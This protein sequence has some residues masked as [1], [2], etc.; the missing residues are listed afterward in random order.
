MSK[1]VL[2]IFVWYRSMR[3]GGLHENIR[4]SITAAEK[5]FERVVVVCPVSWFSEQ[6]LKV[7][8]EVLEVDFGSVSPE[9]VLQKIGNVNFVH[10]HPGQSRILGMKFAKLVQ[11]PVV[12][13][14]H[15]AWFDSVDRYWS[16]LYRVIAVS[17][18]IEFEIRRKI[19]EIRHKLVVINNGVDLGCFFSKDS[20]E[21]KK[22]GF[23]CASRF[24]IDK[25]KLL[26]FV[27]KCWE[28]QAQT[29]RE[30]QWTLAGDG[31]SRKEF[32][33]L[34][35]S[36]IG[37]R[38]VNFLG[39]VQRSELSAVY[40]SAQIAIVPGRSAIE[41]LASGVSVISIGSSGGYVFVRDA[42]SFHQAMFSNFGGYGTPVKDVVYQEVFDFCDQTQNLPS[43][44]L[45][46]MI[47]SYVSLDV[48]NAKLERI[49]QEGLM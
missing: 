47:D 8:A 29:G 6:Y 43:R 49:Y 24:D 25:E 17:Q 18:S 39:W 9:D 13:T 35:I 11:A 27:K 44:D 48:I 19:P 7:G 28:F 41:A 14:I 37:E 30:I 23:V 38:N 12:M 22:I 45:I 33:D 31:P 46:R 10:V 42:E 16:E 5:V 26:S 36:L 34:G 40:R 4:D 21:N 32:V 3:G 1:R 20:I 15:G 2:A